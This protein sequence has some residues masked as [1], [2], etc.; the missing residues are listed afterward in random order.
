MS[1]LDLRVPAGIAGIKPYVAGKPIEELSR[2]YGITD[3]IKL[4]SNENP[5]GPSP[6]A[7]EAVSRALS[8]IHR[9]PDAAAHDLTT[10]L[11]DRLG[12]PPE[13]IVLG[14]GSDEIL[15]LITGVFLQPGDEAILPQPAFLMYEILVRRDGGIP[16]SVPLRGLSIDL[17]EMAR[18][19]TDRTRIV[20]LTHPNNP[21]GELL[22]RAEFET[23]LAAIPPQVIVVMDEA[24]FEFARGP[25]VFSGLAYLESSHPVA[26]LRTFSKAYGLAGLRVGYGVMDPEMAELIQRIRPPFNTSIPAQAGARAALT[27]E[28]FLQQ[29]LTT[30]HEGID[31][32]TAALKEMGLSPHPTQANF[33]LVDVGRS[34][35]D[36]F[37]AMLREGVII[38]SMSA[39]DLPRHVRLTVGRPEDN[40]RL[41]AALERVLGCAD[42]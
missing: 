30:V 34:A 7:V 18:R 24:Y 9:Y 42:C 16:V 10:A 25:A 19:V 13:T 21:T 8:T 40:R 41:V 32:L 39:Y 23:F 27:D 4:A 31:S 33:I 29:T 17:P 2:E 12:V 36:V 14:N 35:D 3:A 1:R 5:I 6:K 37:E 22:D 15:G 11:A 28:A 38:R 26:T 20:F